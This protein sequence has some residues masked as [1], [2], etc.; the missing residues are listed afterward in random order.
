MSKFITKMVESIINFIKGY[1]PVMYNVHLRTTPKEPPI[2]K[3]QLGDVVTKLGELP[4]FDVRFNLK[5]YTI[6]KCDYSKMKRNIIESE[7]SVPFVH[8]ESNYFPET[9]EKNFYIK[10]TIYSLGIDNNVWEFI[11]SVDFQCYTLVPDT[12]ESDVVNLMGHYVNGLISSL[13]LNSM[14]KYPI[15]TLP[16]S[17]LDY[18]MNQY[19]HGYIRDYGDPLMFKDIIADMSTEFKREYPELKTD[20]EKGNYITLDNELIIKGVYAP[21]KISKKEAILTD[22]NGNI[23]H[24]PYFNIS[25]FRKSA[26]IVL[27]YLTEK[28]WEDNLFNKDRIPDKTLF[29]TDSKN[30]DEVNRQLKGH[31]NDYI[32][33]KINDHIR[34][35]ALKSSFENSSYIQSIV[36][37]FSVVCSHDTHFNDLYNSM[38][39]VEKLAKWN[40]AT[41]KPSKG[42]VMKECIDR[43]L[44]A[45]KIYGDESD[46]WDVLYHDQNIL[47]Q[48]LDHSLNN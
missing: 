25:I 19:Y 27:L 48:R 34:I 6:H 1:F 29:I 17:K 41:A 46:K 16:L 47:S 4:V 35:Y 36:A 12:I 39:W 18:T 3:K 26:P 43:I 9:H 22:T 38:Y 24:T 21:Y 8:V 42:K 14:V 40:D 11:F 28:N 2:P 20:S 7:S 31:G 44:S 33:F 32:L 23:Y 15:M 37:G 30:R 5:T 13:D 10:Y 45:E